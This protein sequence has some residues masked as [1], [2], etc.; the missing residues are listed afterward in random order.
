[1]CEVNHL[2]SFQSR[3]HAAT[4]LEV[5]AAVQSIKEGKF[6]K[7]KEPGELQHFK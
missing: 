2:S 5:D 3:R 6:D 1:M 4:A 7:I